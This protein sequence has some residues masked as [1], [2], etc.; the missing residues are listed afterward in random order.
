MTPEAKVKNKV[1]NI[2]KMY[3]AYFLMPRGTALGRNGIPDIIC[4]INGRFVG[5]ECKAGKN[6]PTPL[7]LYEL[8]LIRDNNGIVAV[9][10]EDNIEVVE[11]ICKHCLKIS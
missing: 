4:C 5:I 2:L 9:I 1:K 10:N 7:Q 3:N 11:V 6:K 8:R